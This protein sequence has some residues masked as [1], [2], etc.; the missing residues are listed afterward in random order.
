MLDY[1][2]RI[3]ELSGSISQVEEELAQAKRD[4]TNLVVFQRVH[5]TQSDQFEE[6]IRDRKKRI[7]GA[8][9]NPR[10]VNAYRQYREWMQEALTGRDPKTIY[11]QNERAKG[12]ISRA[13]QEAEARITQLQ[14]GIASLQDEKDDC[15]LAMREEELR[16]EE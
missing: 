2:G 5:Q 3:R 8:D 16:R 6:E 9:L 12:Q 10:E 7:E 11:A 13:I 15:I 4:L 14:A 1:A